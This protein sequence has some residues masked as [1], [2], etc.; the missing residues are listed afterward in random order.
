MTTVLPI[1]LLGFSCG[2]AEEGKVQAGED[3][4]NMVMPSSGEVSVF[5]LGASGAEAG[6]RDLA[7]LTAIPASSR[8]NGGMPAVLALADDGAPLASTLDMLERLAPEEA[9]VMDEDV[10][11]SHAQDTT[12]FS[13]EGAE[14]W[15][16]LL[17]EHFWGTADYAV[18]V[19]DSDYSAAVLGSS[20]AARL[21]APLLI[22]EPAGDTL[23]AVASSL[24]AE[25]LSVGIEYPPADLPFDHIPLD[26]LES[27]LAWVHENGVEIPYIA[28]SNPNDRY[29]GRSQKASMVA[30]MY[31][32][33]R[34]GLSL[35]VALDMPTA[36]VDDGGEH[37]VLPALADAYEGLGGPPVHLAIVGAHDALPQMR[38]P[39]IFD[40]PIGEQPVSDLP[41][42]E[43][44]A[45]PFL[46]LAIGRVVGDTLEELSVVATRTSQYD[47]LKD[48]VWE[49]RFVE[50]GL[51]G[52]DELRSP[53]LNVG[54]ET[55]E[56]LSLADIEALHSIEAGAFLHKDHSYCQVL[57]N[58]VDVN[59]STLFAPAFVVSRG[60]S[61][62]GIDL[63]QEDQRSI[64][65]HMFGQGIVAF[66]GAARNSIAYN[67][68]IEVSLWNQLLDGR[69]LGES[70]RHG[71]NDAIVHWLDDGSDA[72]RYSIDIEI[73]YGD[74]ALQLHVPGGYETAPASQELD[75]ST[76]TVRAPEV[77]TLVEYHPDQL[78]E[79]GYGGELFMYTGSGA[80]P[81]TYWSGSYDSED[82]YFG[83]Q[84]PLAEAP[85]TVQET[86]EQPSPLGWGGVSHIDEHA[87][88]TVSAMWRV[89][90]LD[91]DEQTGEISA[92][93]DAFVYELD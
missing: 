9:Y 4:G 14:E 28:V 45:D 10:A 50:S 56:H 77:W 34:G 27:T 82:M 42:G 91:F 2:G 6:W 88:G 58:A 62:G 38:R 63:L 73:V 70:F 68:I 66:V 64:V 48:G 54:Y 1:A 83:V 59:N 60:C 11:V 81:R 53:M 46:D 55:P 32:A 52:F 8:R 67:T 57:G 19:S 24:G 25:V 79:W 71:I 41:Y 85:S 49:R 44:D 26:G 93:Q 40:N 89:R 29:S 5:V 65:D 22:D 20:L 39:T 31:A 13:A 18:V 16:L 12:V 74:P 84:Q 47:R 7:F 33:R 69:T 37:P 36:V 3:T 87:D 15:S 78:A 21:G 92:D 30:P 43:I 35:P 61:V 80:I 76:L 51:W 86:G 72:M 75:G 17:A 90:L 23:E